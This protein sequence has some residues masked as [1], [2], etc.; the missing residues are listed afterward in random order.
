ML[1]SPLRPDLCLSYANTLSWRGTRAP[2]ESLRDFAGL[3]GWLERAAGMDAA[4]MREVARWSDRQ[5]RRAARVFAEAIGLREALYRVLSR[6]A[7]GTPRRRD[8]AMLQQALADAP[9]RRHLVEMRSAYAWRIDTS[10]PSVPHLLAPVLWSAGDLLAAG[11]RRR[12]R[13]CANDAC[14]WL[15]IDASRNAT[16]RWCDMASCGNRAKARR[17]YLKAKG[18]LI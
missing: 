14:R 10:R 6:L 8:L 3:L 2:A 7:A 18:G 15:F 13:Q 16:R 1:I 12:L 17:H 4:A 11:D 5:P 9:V